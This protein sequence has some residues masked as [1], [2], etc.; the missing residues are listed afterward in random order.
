MREFPRIFIGVIEGWLRH[1][2]IHLQFLH[3]DHHQSFGGV[4]VSQRTFCIMEI[5]YICR[6]VCENVFNSRKF[7][8]LPLLDFAFIV[9]HT[10]KCSKY[11][12]SVGATG[13]SLAV[14][15]SVIVRD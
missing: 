7:L 10:F 9:F 4:T 13:S 8:P 5:P 6:C 12:K 11:I 15:P 1:C 2:T 3:V 14:E